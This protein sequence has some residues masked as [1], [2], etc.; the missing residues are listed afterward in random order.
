MH[1][2]ELYNLGHMIEA[3]VAHYEATGKRNFLDMA[4]RTADLISST[5][6]PDRLRD[7]PGHQE[8]ELALAKLYK[9][10]GKKEYIETARFFLDE[11][12]HYNG[13]EQYIFRGKNPTYFQDHL[14]VLDQ[15]E[16]TGHAVRAC[17]MYAGMVDVGALSGHVEYIEASNRLW[18][19]AT[20]K[21]IYITGGVG[22]S[23][24]KG[25]AFDEAYMLPNLKAYAE[26]CGAVANMLWNFRLAKYYKDAKYF[27][28]LERTL[29]NAYLPTHS[30]HGVGYFYT[31]PLADRGSKRRSGWFDPP[32][33]PT[34]ICRTTTSVPGY[35]YLVDKQ[36]LYVN[37][38]IES[39]SNLEIGGENIRLVQETGYPW[40][41]IVN[42][43]VRMD[44]PSRFT[45]KIRVPGWAREEAIPL[46]LYKY[47][48]PMRSD[49]LLEVNGKEQKL[50]LDKG[51]AV[52]DRKW[53]SDDEISLSLPMEVRRV[54]SDEQ[55][56][57]NRGMVALERGPILFC[58]EGI[59]NNGRTSNI[60]LPDESKLSER[61][62]KNLLGGISVIE[63][64]NLTAI[65]Y[66]AWLN[67][68]EGEMDVWIP[69]DIAA[70]RN[71]NY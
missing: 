66:F 51:Y 44:K 22:A 61:Y 32:C 9:V 54:V 70:L 65:P 1:S 8:I 19:N 36:S 21:K 5:F 15:E 55:V 26:T 53:E 30:L 27:D 10:T 68:G 7:I 34:N 4:I 28:V 41:G 57:E 60:V 38:F 50:V 11:R 43:K 59:D 64:A 52:I 6:G 67:R 47:L 31:N 18:E 25:E 48:E 62:I 12:G 17:Y 20:G 45:L 23:H 3:A 37:L 29:Y 71:R 14:P 13:R 16:T 58:I 69:R 24:T 56:K 42:L 35:V 2:H 39:E 49:V 40:S 46:G 63:G 33:C